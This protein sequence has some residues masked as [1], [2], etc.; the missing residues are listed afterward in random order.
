MLRAQVVGA[1]YGLAAG[2]IGGEQRVDQGLVGSPGAL[3]GTDD[4]GVFAHESHVD[5]S[6]RVGGGRQ[7]TRCAG[8]ELRPAAASA[9]VGDNS[10]PKS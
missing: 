1:S 6:P 10:E 8:R 2:L 3:A 7:G 5:H 4:L 9:V